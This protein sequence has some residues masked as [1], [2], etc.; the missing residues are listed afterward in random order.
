VGARKVI[1]DTSVFVAGII[2]HG[3]SKI[4]LDAIMDCRIIPILC[5][6]ILEEYIHVIHYPKI[7]KKVS[8]SNVYSI[9]DA[10]NRKAEYI[11]Y[12]GKIHVCR[13]PEDDKFIELSAKTSAPLITLD[14]DILDMR[15]EK[16]ML[17]VNS[18]QIR[19]FKPREFLQ[20]V[21]L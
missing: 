4:I 5:S 18:E 14:N 10:I 19:I 13:D 16:K 21:P 6:E 2:G 9:I 1:L 11:T 3:A 15:D 20:E 17:K 8:L 7:A 12:K